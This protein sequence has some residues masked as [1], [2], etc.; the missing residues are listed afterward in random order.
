ME[1]NDCDRL[2]ERRSPSL[3]RVTM[4]IVLTAGV[5]AAMTAFSGVGFAG[6]SHGTP[7]NDQYGH[8]HH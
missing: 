8:H 7:A 1:V 6:T 5:L 3:R 2:A 4:A